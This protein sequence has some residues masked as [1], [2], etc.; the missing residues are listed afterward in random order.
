MLTI[1]A[2]AILIALVWVGVSTAM[3]W[4][5]QERVVFQPPSVWA[6][7]QLATR[8]NI[9]DFTLA[10][11]TLFTIVNKIQHSLDMNTCQAV[12]HAHGI[13]LPRERR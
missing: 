8:S 7:A 11:A 2:M 1:I 4:R 13:R 3:L 12:R 10:V 5:H 6:K 9:H